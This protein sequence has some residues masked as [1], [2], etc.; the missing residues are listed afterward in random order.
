MSNESPSLAFLV[1]L[2]VIACSR[3]MVSE[4]MGIRQS[5]KV[6]CGEIDESKTSVKNADEWLE[7]G[8]EAKA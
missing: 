4:S 5:R 7:R 8:Y 2:L 1:L 6:E 3:Q